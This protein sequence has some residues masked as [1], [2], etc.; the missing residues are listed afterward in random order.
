V[1]DDGFAAYQ[2]RQGRLAAEVA[3]LQRTRLVPGPDGAARLAA[4]GVA[5]L[6]RPVTLAEL[7]RRPEA[8]YHSLAPV[9]P[10]RPAGLGELGERA[11]ITI[12]Y[13]GYIERQAKA[14]ERL[15]RLEGVA[16]PPEVD[17]H[18]IIGLSVEVRQKLAT[19]RPLTI[20]QAGRISGVTPAALSLLLVYL[21]AQGAA[22]TIS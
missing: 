13:Q 20:G 7:L 6:S 21:R 12:K 8:D 11:A 1:N 15:H 9:D 16:I 3:R 19:V 2:E 5:P 4:V 18:A 10:E 17:F 22:A 14:V